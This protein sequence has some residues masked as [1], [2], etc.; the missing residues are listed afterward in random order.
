ATCWVPHPAGPTDRPH[1]MGTPRAGTRRRAPAVRIPGRAALRARPA[2]AAALTGAAPTGAA[3][4]VRA[5]APA[6]RPGEQE[7]RTARSGSTPGPTPGPTRRP[8]RQTLV[9]PAGRRPSQRD[10]P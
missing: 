3:A 9:A 6:A 7:L 10:P 5:P 1:R 2:P 8:G 4:P